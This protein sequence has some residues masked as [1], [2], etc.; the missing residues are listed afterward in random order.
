[1]SIN[2]DRHIDRKS[3]SDLKWH[4]SLVKGYLNVDISEDM[5]P[6]WLADTDFACAPCI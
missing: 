5:I 3:T 2:F 4:T 6:M 1:M